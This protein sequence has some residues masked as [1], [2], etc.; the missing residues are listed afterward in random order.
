MFALLAH[1]QAALKRF[2]QLHRKTLNSKLTN[3]ASSA[4]SAAFFFRRTADR[5]ENGRDN[6]DIT[7]GT[8]WLSHIPPW[9]S[10]LLLTSRSNWTDVSSVPLS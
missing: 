10:K 4:P 9:Y 7:F 8:C 3:L 5:A 6:G 2:L 1:A